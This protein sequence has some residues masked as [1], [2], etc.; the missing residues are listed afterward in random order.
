[1]I[2]VEQ[3]FSLKPGD[4]ERLIEGA[5]FVSTETM[6]DVYWDTPNVTLISGEAFLRN[7]NGR[8]ELKIPLHKLTKELPKSYHYREIYDEDEIRKNLGIRKQ[9]S[10]FEDLGRAGFSVVADFT[11][12]RT[13][14]RRDQFILDFDETDFGFSVVEVERQVE[15]GDQRQT[16]AQSILDFAKKNGL[17]IKHVRG[18]IH[19][20]LMLKRPDLWE[21]VKTAWEQ[22][23]EH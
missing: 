17:E 19:E 22:W 11:T 21:R 20:Y 16:A 15:R 7:R 14:Y 8:F 3:K 6:R 13:K 5:T 23:P 1:M 9:G 2:E 18:K 10:M 12:T 4:R